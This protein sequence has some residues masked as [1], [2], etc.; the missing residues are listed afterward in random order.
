VKGIGKRIRSLR[1]SRGW[2]QRQLAARLEVSQPAVSFWELED[3]HPDSTSP[4]D[5]NLYKLAGL[6]KV[7]PQ[8]LLFGDES[9]GKRR[10][11]AA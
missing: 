11:R 9:D 2:N 1:K 5:D 4:S 3:G 8:Y 10:R 7:T 6:F